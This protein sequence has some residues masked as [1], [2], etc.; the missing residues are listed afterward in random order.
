MKV[1]KIILA[2][3][4]L[5]IAI[6]IGSRIH[7]DIRKKLNYKNTYAIQ[8]V[9]SGKNLRPLD[10]GT[11][12]GTQLIL[13]DH[14]EWECMTWQ[15]IQL[16]GDVHLVK[17]LF[18]QKTFQPASPDGSDAGLWQQELGGSPL[19]YWE[20]L[21]QEDDTYLIRLQQTDLYLTGSS[22]ETNSPVALMPRQ[23]SRNQLWRL[24][25]QTPWI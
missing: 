22:E 17:N 5:A 10:A 2:A 1:A 21:R 4:L 11:D 8:N 3:V 23:S 25:R 20:F 18:T 6:P 12:D 14:R 9:Q 15:L 19:Q 13:Y 16:N 7:T 24:V